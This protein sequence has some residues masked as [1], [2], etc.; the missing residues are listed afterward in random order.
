MAS[1]MRPQAQCATQRATVGFQRITV[2]PA[3]EGDLH[4]AGPGGEPEPPTLTRRR[5][6]ISPRLSCAVVGLL[7]RDPRLL[8][9][10]AFDVQGD[11]RDGS[12]RLETPTSGVIGHFQDRNMND[13]GLRILVFIS[14]S[15]R[16][17]IPRAHSDCG[18]LNL[19]CFV[20]AVTSGSL[21]PPRALVVAPL[22][23]PA[24][25]ELVREPPARPRRAASARAATGS[26]RARAGRP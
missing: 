18:G 10:R 14:R 22:A 12:D 7:G 21:W 13:G 26:S 5:A 9:A 23:P 1:T 20:V 16:R 11:S 25:R 3:P 24:P 6:A 15:R 8:R 17:G 2:G 19:G 4:G